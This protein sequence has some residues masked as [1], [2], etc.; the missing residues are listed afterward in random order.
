MGG[1]SGQHR[2]PIPVQNRPRIP[3]IICTGFSGKINDQYTRAM[4]VKGF[5]MNQVATGVLAVKVSVERDDAERLALQY[6]ILFL[7]FE[8]VH[9][10]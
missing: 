10:C 5:P 6:V 7:S 1:D 2:P 9:Y 4:G 8:E 3:I